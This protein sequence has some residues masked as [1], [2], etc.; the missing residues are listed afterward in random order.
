MS[1]K[2]YYELNRECNWTMYSEKICHT[3]RHRIPMKTNSREKLRAVVSHD[4]Q[5]DG[6]SRE[7]AKWFQSFRR[8]PFGDDFSAS[9]ARRNLSISSH[10]QTVARSLALG[11]TLRPHC[12][13]SPR[14]V[15]CV[16]DNECLVCSTAS[17]FL[18]IGNHPRSN[19]LYVVVK[20]CALGGANVVLMSEHLMH[21]GGECAE[22]SFIW[23]FWLASE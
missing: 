1:K 19:R 13:S 20:M 22:Y 4:K 11:S 6:Q 15:M 23:V 12:S 3:D 7:C 10:R 9:T 8:M 5:S 21:V 16:C 17:R 2:I 18:W 14:L